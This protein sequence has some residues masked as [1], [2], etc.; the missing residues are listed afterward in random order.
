MPLRK[1][2]RPVH[3]VHDQG[4]MA[5]RSPPQTTIAGLMTQ[6]GLGAARRNGMGRRRLELMQGLANAAGGPC[7]G[8]KCR[9]VAKSVQGPG[10]SPNSV[11]LPPTAGSS[12]RRRVGKILLDLPA[13][14]RHCRPMVTPRDAPFD[15]PGGWVN[16]RGLFRGRA[17][18]VF[19]AARSLGQKWSGGARQAFE[20]ALENIC[21]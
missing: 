5:F 21:S 12:R 13:T 8:G 19:A 6:P 14:S 9:I 1:T 20:L 17:C 15:Q 4:A 10:P 18:G 3:S 11:D 16:Q 2:C 7:F